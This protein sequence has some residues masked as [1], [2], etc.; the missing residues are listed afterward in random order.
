MKGSVERDYSREFAAL[1]EVL[2]RTG[3]DA[4]ALRNP[5]IA[6]LVVH[7]NRVLGLNALPGIAMDV[8]PLPDGI[9]A[10]VEVRSGVV[11]P[12]PVHLCFGVLPKEGVQ[13]I[14]STFRI[15]EGASVQF[16]AH[17]SFPNAEKVQH[18]MEAELEIGE[19]ATMAYTEV[20]YHG[21][22]G[23]TEVL[24]KARI[25]V[26]RNGRYLSEFKLIQGRVGLLSLDY[27]VHLGEGA[28]TELVSKVYG[29][30]EDRIAIREA[31]HLEGPYARGLVKS[32]IVLQDRAQAEFTGEALGIGPY[33]RGHI[34][35]TEILRGTEARASAVPKLIVVDERAK[36]TH[37]A[38]IGSIDRKILET[39]MARGLPEEEAVE[40]V[41]RGLL[42]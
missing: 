32:R 12:D 38:A 29:K 42:R 18:I 31:L 28:V 24:P 39:L 14:L 27:T 16:L 6:S 36:L 20:H 40:V 13:R 22:Y 33:S 7:Q 21:P 37:E 9:R 35:C 26:H 2:E 41:V 34:D 15:G 1:A 30:G 5:R 17:C 8:D 4:A 11:I 10:H 19:G 3:G 25:R 23:G